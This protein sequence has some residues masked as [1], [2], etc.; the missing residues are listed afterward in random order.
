MPPQPDVFLET[1]L[2]A[3]RRVPKF[4]GGRSLNDYLADEFCQSAVE[5]QLEIAGDA[6]GGYLFVSGIDLDVRTKVADDLGWHALQEL[7]EESHEGDLCMKTFWP[8]H[9]AGLEALNKKRRDWKRRYAAAFQVLPCDT[10]APK[11]AATTEL[12]SEAATQ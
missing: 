9:Y 7:L 1:A 4:L 10:K 2:L 8:W 12:S 3:L 6:L 11:V 5:R